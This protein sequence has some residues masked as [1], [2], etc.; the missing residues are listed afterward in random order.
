M[1]DILHSL[2]EKIVLNLVNVAQSLDVGRLQ[3]NLLNIS[4][5]VLNRFLYF[6]L[7]NK[8]SR[9]PSKHVG[10]NVSIAITIFLLLELGLEGSNC[11]VH[12]CK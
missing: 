6:C 11:C 10:L 5:L 1:G 2:V 7:I 8:P 9:I 12:M 3:I 4:L